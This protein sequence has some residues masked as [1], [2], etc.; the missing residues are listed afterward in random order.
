[1]PPLC[2]REDHLTI[3]GHRAR[4]E[5]D[6]ERELLLGRFSPACRN[7]LAPRHIDGNRFSQVD[8]FARIDGGSGLFGMK[9]WRRFNCHRVQFLLQLNRL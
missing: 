8:V 3:R 2:T 5:I 6:A 7:G 1:M 9:V 4:L